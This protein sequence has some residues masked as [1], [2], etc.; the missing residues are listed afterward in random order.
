MEGVVNSVA[1]FGIRSR[2]DDVTDAAE[3]DRHASTPR[4]LDR[5]SRATARSSRTNGAFTLV[6]LLLTISII[7]LVLALVLVAVGQLQTRARATACLSN[8]RQI[9][10]ANQTYAADNDGRFVNPRTDPYPPTG[11]MRGVSNCW[12]NTGATNGTT[13]FA[14]PGLTERRETV[15]ALEGGAMWRYLGENPAAYQSPMD[16]T[17]R[18]RSYSLSSFVGVGDN[19]PGRSADDF[20]TFPDNFSTDAPEGVRDT[21]FKTVTP[22]AST[23]MDSPCRCRR[24]SV[25]PASGSTRPLYGTP[26]ASTSRMSTD[27]SIRRT[28]ST[29]NLRTPSQPTQMDTT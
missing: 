14:G 18:L 13:L 3:T 20:F 21:Q 8:Q 4:Q 23:C 28:S 29:R 11:G 26:G 6:E 10:L 27:R 2:H 5:N 22:S 7:A 9:A 25:P 16:P 17:G 24:P 12:V 1:I 19:T 15:R